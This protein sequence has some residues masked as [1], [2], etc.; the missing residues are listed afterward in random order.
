MFNR[1]VAI[2]LIPIILLTGCA[3]KFSGMNNTSS[4]CG[5][6]DVHFDVFAEC[7]KTKLIAQ[8]IDPAEAKKADE[9]NMRTFAPKDSSPGVLQAQYLSDL[10]NLLARYEDK[11]LAKKKKEKKT[12]TLDKIAYDQFDE[13]TRAAAS[14]EE[15]QNKKAQAMVAVM[16]VGA[17]A[18]GAASYCSRH[19]CGGGGG[20]STNHQGCCSWHNGIAEGCGPH[21][22]LICN[23]GSES[24][25]CLCD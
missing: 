13:L 11:T 10:D 21:G 22:R 3:S 19:H 4:E 8:S 14:L 5:Y 15:A 16:L 23:D 17:A 9:F 24:P 20:Y 25:T 6:R 1:I 2:F 12:E 7:L 18:I